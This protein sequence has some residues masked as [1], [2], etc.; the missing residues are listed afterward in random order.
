ME[1]GVMIPS[2]FEQGSLEETGAGRDTPLGKK[3]GAS[4]F[5]TK[6]E[7]KKEGKRGSEGRGKSSAGQTGEDREES[8][9]CTD[10]GT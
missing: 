1:K 7:K 8:S 4:W 2:R 3:T 9:A 6:R 10:A 5:P